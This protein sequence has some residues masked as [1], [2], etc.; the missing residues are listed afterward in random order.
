MKTLLFLITFAVLPLGAI[1]AM[2]LN[3]ISFDVAN[4]LILA[5]LCLSIAVVAYID[6]E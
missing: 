5:G 6:G 1:A 2:L 3:A 4:V